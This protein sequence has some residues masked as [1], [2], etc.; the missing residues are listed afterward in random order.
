MIRARVIRSLSI[1]ELN[2]YSNVLMSWQG[3]VSY[4]SCLEVAHGEERSKMGPPGVGP[5]LEESENLSFKVLRAG[6]SG[7]PAQ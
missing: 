4:N 7:N 6:M 3:L 2:G 5:L 1:P